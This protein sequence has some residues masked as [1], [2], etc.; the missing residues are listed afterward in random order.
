MLVGMLGV[1]V[2][3]PSVPQSSRKGDRLVNLSGRLFSLY[4]VEGRVLGLL[5]AAEM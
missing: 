2:P 1:A 4:L 3:E 5:R